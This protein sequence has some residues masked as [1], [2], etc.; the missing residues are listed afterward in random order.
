MTMTIEN[1]CNNF[2]TNIIGEDDSDKG[3]TGVIRVET[4]PVL[5]NTIV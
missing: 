4:I 5:V 3:D 2:D 1:Y